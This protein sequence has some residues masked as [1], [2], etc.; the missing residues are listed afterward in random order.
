MT[1]KELREALNS[2]VFNDDDEVLVENIGDR[3]CAVVLMTYQGDE[4]SLIFVADRTAP[5]V[6]EIRAIRKWKEA[7][8]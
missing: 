4:G 5:L 8:K 7:I 1:A 6:D 2:F 3:A